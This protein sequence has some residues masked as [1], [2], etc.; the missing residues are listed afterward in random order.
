MTVLALS[1]AAAAPLPEDAFLSFTTRSYLVT[2][3]AKL[4]WLEE[5]RGV[6][7]IIGCTLPS[8]EPRKL[9]NYTSEDGGAV[10]DHLALSE[11]GATVLYS[12]GEEAAVNP[13][14]AAAP[15]VRRSYSLAFASG[16][17]PTALAPYSLEAATYD[18]RGEAAYVT[19]AIASNGHTTLA[20]MRAT[21]D[22]ADADD[23]SAAREDCRR[24]RG[25]LQWHPRGGVGTGRSDSRVCH[26]TPRP[27]LHWPLDA[28][29]VEPAASESR[30]RATTARRVIPFTQI[31]R[32]RRA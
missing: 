22:D 18:T 5:L 23:A 14:S 24:S 11:D 15:L 8:C 6:T 13:S 16:A 9:T 21:G 28:R 10:I 31:T 12:R 26:S 3:G 30:Q 20:E 32:P 4:A 25:H 2:A 1:S 17:L 27:Q 29:H 7:N 19:F